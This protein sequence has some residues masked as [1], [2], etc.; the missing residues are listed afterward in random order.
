MVKTAHGLPEAM[1]GRPMQ[2]LRDRL[3]HLLDS[4]ATRRAEASVCYVT[5]ELHDHYRNAHAGLRTAVIENGICNIERDALRRPLELTHGWFNLAIVGRLDT[6]KGH[7][8]AIEAVASK[9]IPRDVHLHVLGTGPNEDGLRRL[10]RTLGVADRV[11]FHGFRED[12]YEFVAHSNAV[13]IPSLHEGLPYTLLEAMAVATPIVASRTGGLEA[14][15]RHEKTAL[16]VPPRDTVALAEAILRLY[17]DPL[18]A[19]RLGESARRL[20]QSRYSVDAM[21][22]AYVAI[23]RELTAS[24]D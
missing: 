1:Q 5:A 3:Y 12:I 20:Q 18:L 16:L 6:V 15:L 19:T 21:T 17:R 24:C 7:S 9:P 8:F 14:V 10:A 23:Y 2:A 11:H 13:L 4:V 22:D